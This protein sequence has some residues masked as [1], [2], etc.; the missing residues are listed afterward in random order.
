[1][2]LRMALDDK[3]LDVRLRDR[4]V[5]EGKISNEQVEEYLKSVPDDEGNYTNVD[6]GREVAA[7][8]STDQ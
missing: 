2:K 8:T 4:L 3:L 6:E 7:S 1:M 5:S